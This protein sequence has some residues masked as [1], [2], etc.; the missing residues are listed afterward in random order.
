MADVCEIEVE[1]NENPLLRLANSRDRLILRTAELLVVNRVGVVTAI[2]KPGR[3][4]DGQILIQFEP[5]AAALT[6][7]ITTRS[8]A[9]SAAYAIAAATSLG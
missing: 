5:H 9:S 8:R 3:R 1:C 7:V 4:F 6:G 2:S